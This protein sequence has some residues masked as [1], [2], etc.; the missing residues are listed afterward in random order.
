M[1][2]AGRITFCITSICCS[3][4]GAPCPA[5]RGNTDSHSVLRTVAVRAQADLLLADLR[6]TSAK[7]PQTRV[8]WTSSTQS[9]NPSSYKAVIE[10]NEK[11]TSRRRETRAFSPR[12]SG[13]SGCS[14]GVISKAVSVH[15]MCLCDWRFCDSDKC[16]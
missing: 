1:A 13:D 9:G 14:R 10:A 3:R 7:R 12:I 16:R 8:E 6:P 11:R 4:Y 2:G 15:P 5:S